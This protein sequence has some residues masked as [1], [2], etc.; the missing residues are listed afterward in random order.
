MLPE[1]IW[2]PVPSRPRLE[3]SSHGRIRATARVV[4]L[5]RGGFLLAGTDPTF[6][7]VAKS[8]ADARH[9]YF[10]RHIK[11]IGNVKV[12]QAVCEA[13][14]GPRPFPEAV[15]LH[16][17]ENGLDNRPSNLAWGTQKEN[18]NMPRF[19]E[20]CR[21]RTGDNNPHVKGRRSAQEATAG[22]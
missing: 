10:S 16:L 8:K 7:V 19:I 20:Y 5:P 2:K 1:E 21:S 22:K 17:N 14:H 4:F 13:F 6:G 15:V 9:L 18:L 11:K 3:A 12:H